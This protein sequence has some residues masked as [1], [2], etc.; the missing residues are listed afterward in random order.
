MP[1]RIDEIGEQ[2]ELRRVLLAAVDG[3][4][5]AVHHDPVP[6]PAD[7]RGTVPPVPQGVE[8]RPGV[9]VEDDEP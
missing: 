2:G 9:V 7:G 5:P 8:V 3:V 6:P 4:A 1:G